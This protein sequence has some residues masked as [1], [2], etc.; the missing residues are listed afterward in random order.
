MSSHETLKKENGIHW[1]ETAAKKKKKR[2]YDLSLDSGERKKD[3]PRQAYKEPCP[4]QRLD[5]V[6]KRRGKTESTR[7][8][9]AG[10]K[11]RLST[12]SQTREK[13]DDTPSHCIGSL[14]KEKP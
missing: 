9:G 14:A 11:G 2:K 3:S 7:P 12:A 13:G 4:S 8:V 5:E 1:S 10:K 6:K